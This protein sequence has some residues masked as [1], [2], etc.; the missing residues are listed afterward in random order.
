MGEVAEMMLDGTLCQHCGTFIGEAEGYP[1][2]C[3][4]CKPEHCGSNLY[5]RRARKIKFKAEASKV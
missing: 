4:S 2:T 5:R 3:D 1:K